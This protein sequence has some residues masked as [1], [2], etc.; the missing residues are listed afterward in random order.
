MRLYVGDLDQ[1]KIELR[2]ASGA[3]IPS[4]RSHHAKSIQLISVFLAS[5]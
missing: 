1:R 3:A 5:H 4:C 2:Q